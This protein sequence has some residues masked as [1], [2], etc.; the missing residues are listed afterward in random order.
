MG[1]L[2]VVRFTDLTEALGRLGHGFRVEA[3]IVVW[4]DRDALTV[5]SSAL[6]RSD[7]NG[8]WAVFVLEDGVARL[9]I[10]EAGRDNGVEAQVL[11]GL[12]PGEQV[13]LYPASNLTDETQIVR[14]KAGS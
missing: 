5:P 7:G 14:R 1:E 4:E 8:K 13:I 9:R 2:A 6:F 10:V 11:D 3:R 12:R